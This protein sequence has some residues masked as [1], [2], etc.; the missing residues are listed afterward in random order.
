M[1]CPPAVAVRVETKAPHIRSAARETTTHPETR[2]TLMNPSRATPRESR[3]S[4]GDVEIVTTRSVTEMLRPDSVDRR[5][6]PPALDHPCGIELPDARESTQ[7]RRRRAEV[8]L[9][10]E[11]L[12]DLAV[13]VRRRAELPEG[14]CDEHL[15]HLSGHRT[16][17]EGELTHGRTAPRVVELLLRQSSKSSHDSAGVDPSRRVEACRRV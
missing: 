5:L 12:E 11:D 17:V 16:A 7:H 9:V 10:V 3:Q 13:S 14:R 4:V 1:D 15:D 6:V 2:R 8:Q